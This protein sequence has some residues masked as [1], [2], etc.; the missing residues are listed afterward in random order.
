[1]TKTES[2]SIAHIDQ[3]FNVFNI[4]AMPYFA[5][6]LGLYQNIENPI[7]FASNNL[8][9][10]KDSHSN[11]ASF[12]KIAQ[13]Y[14]F[15]L[16]YVDQLE[17]QQI[18][19]LP[20]LANLYAAGLQLSDEK[21]A[22][23]VLTSLIAKHLAKQSGNSLCEQPHLDDAKKIVAA[24]KAYL[25]QEAAIDAMVYMVS[26][27]CKEPNNYILAASY[28]KKA[29]L[30]RL[31]GA[32]IFTSNNYSK[33]NRI[34]LL[35][36]EAQNIAMQAEE[37]QLDDAYIILNV[38][39][40]LIQQGVDAKLA[41]AVA[42][43]CG[44]GFF[45]E[46]NHSIPEAF[47]LEQ[48]NGSLSKT[49]AIINYQANQA[50]S[51]KFLQEYFKSGHSIEQAIAAANQLKEEVLS[52][53]SIEGKLDSQGEIP[54]LCWEAF[55]TVQDYAAN[56]YFS[57]T[58]GAF[59]IE[60][61]NQGNGL[62][63]AALKA[64]QN[65]LIADVDNPIHKLTPEQ[66]SIQIR[67]L[68]PN[69]RGLIVDQFNNIIRNDA[70][71]ISVPVAFVSGLKILQQSWHNYESLPLEEK[72]SLQ[73]DITI[74]LSDVSN[75]YIDFANNNP[76]VG[77]DIELNII[78]NYYG[79]QIKQHSHLVDDY[80]VINPNEK[81]IV[82]IFY[83]IHQN[84][85]YGLAHQSLNIAAEPIPQAAYIEQASAA[86]EQGLTK[87]YL[88]TAIA[89]LAQSN[90]IIWEAN[91]PINKELL[92]QTIKDAS[93]A[94]AQ[95]AKLKEKELQDKKT[96]ANIDQSENI[97]ERYS[98]FIPLRLDNQLKLIPKEVELNLASI[99]LLAAEN[100]LSRMFKAKRNK[101]NFSLSQHKE[102]ISRT[103]TASDRHSAALIALESARNLSKLEERNDKMI[104][105]QRAMASASLEA[106]QVATMEAYHQ[107]WQNII[108]QQLTAIDTAYTTVDKQITQYIDDLTKINHRTC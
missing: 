46:D 96:T 29:E 105:R 8:G 64:I 40:H 1:M 61:N 34:R 27:L 9:T 51:I 67:T 23:A 26:S 41:G 32:T 88:E 4:Y 75:Y 100:A 108:K 72:K 103:S 20:E 86:A 66:L 102:V 30:K 18:I 107:W 81:L 28:A 52:L 37:E 92:Q 16:I 19:M 10:Q 49:E 60:R 36:I 98:L 85:Y 47:H 78:A 42:I 24:T 35:L 17:T 95:S 101:V 93:L 94:I 45:F 74:Y 5:L 56:Y 15:L 76:D 89:L 6:S 43:V 57:P 73:Q 69:A 21:V 83:A 65:A 97:T 68:L 53:K 87:D 71:L 104:E 7:Q 12:E 38:K 2:I 62:Y 77:G 55:T 31:S 22:T 25:T 70:S 90:V 14:N 63:T 58:N 91:N 106:L 54:K 3:E 33:V 50:S 48:S 99:Q 59:K 11:T 84:R 82:H 39:Q 80:K 79:V 13:V 44:A